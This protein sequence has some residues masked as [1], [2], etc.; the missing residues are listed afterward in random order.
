MIEY[1]DPIQADL[2]K[3]RMPPADTTREK[4]EQPLVPEQP[5][6]VLARGGRQLGSSRPTARSVSHSRQRRANLW[7]DG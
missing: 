6:I 1:A 2:A 7:R 4:L 5:V 3:R